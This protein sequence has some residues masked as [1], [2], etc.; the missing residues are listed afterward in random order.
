M[1]SFV[2]VDNLK[3]RFLTRTKFD[4]QLVL[5]VLSIGTKNDQIQAVKTVEIGLVIVII[6]QVM[7]DQRVLILDGNS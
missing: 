7:S 6:F 5:S 3:F 4:F 2:N 1:N